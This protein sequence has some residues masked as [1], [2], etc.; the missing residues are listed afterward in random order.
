MEKSQSSKSNVIDADFLKKLS[1]RERTA[2]WMEQ[3]E[4]AIAEGQQV[5]DEIHELIEE[6]EK[7]GLA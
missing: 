2:F 1:R 3:R 4:K 7:R 6:I 5:L